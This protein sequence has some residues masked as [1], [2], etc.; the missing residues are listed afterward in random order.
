MGADKPQVIGSKPI[1]ETQK[2]GRDSVVG[3]MVDRDF[4]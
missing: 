1:E 2:T 3:L 4:P